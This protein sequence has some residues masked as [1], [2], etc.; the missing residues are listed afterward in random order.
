MWAALPG[1]LLT[2]LGMWAA[3]PGLLLTGPLA[4]RTTL[5]WQGDFEE[6][7]ML[8]QQREALDDQVASLQYR[9]RWAPAP[10]TPPPPP[11]PQQLPSPSSHLLT[12][13]CMPVSHATWLH[14]VALA[15]LPC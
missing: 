3:L 7:R 6:L 1:L 4:D 2:G 11:P 8:R 13:W 12:L 5:G 9:L 14:C 10:C 15:A